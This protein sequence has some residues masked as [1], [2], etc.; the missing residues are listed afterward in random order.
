MFFWFT[1]APINSQQLNESLNEPSVGAV[2]VFEGRVRNHNQDREVTLLEYEAYERLANKEAEKIIQ[3]AYEK[4]SVVK[5]CC[6]HRLGKLTVGESAVW[7]G[8]SAAHR[9]GAFQACRYIIDQVKARLPI[10]KK[11]T[12][13]D[14]S[15]GWIMCEEERATAACA[16]GGNPRFHEHP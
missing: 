12:Y 1:H 2:V 14:G 5:A 10:W 7:V 3:E 4:F 9:D 11:E 16:M 6:V 15:S 13:T 8:V